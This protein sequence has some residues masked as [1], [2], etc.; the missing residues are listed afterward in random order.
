MPMS[1]KGI[2]IRPIP[3]EKQAWLLHKEA[4]QT[5][6]YSTNRKPKKIAPLQIRTK[7]TVL[8]AMQRLVLN[9]SAK[10][11]LWITHR[12]RD[13]VPVRNARQQSQGLGDAAPS[14]ATFIDQTIV[15]QTVI[16]SQM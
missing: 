3:H 14:E 9:G 1:P 13:E 2:V 15:A 11:G 16:L 8:P 6:R 12:S 4:K 7:E 10:D 5:T